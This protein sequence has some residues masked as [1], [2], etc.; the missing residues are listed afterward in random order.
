M[1]THGSNSASYIQQITIETAPRW[2][3][4]IADPGSR[5]GHPRGLYD[6][7]IIRVPWLKYH[8][9]GRHKTVAD[10]A[11]SGTSDIES[12]AVADRLRDLGYREWPD[13]IGNPSI[14]TT[15]GNSL[16]FLEAL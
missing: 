1:M 11:N 13:T 8:Q 14:L 9:N 10:V 6:D 2:R 16:G 7:S 12:Q 3:A 5:V 4:C 15:A